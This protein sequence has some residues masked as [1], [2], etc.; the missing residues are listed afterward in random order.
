MVFANPL[1]W[2]KMYS[3]PSG[4][5]RWVHRVGV[6]LVVPDTTRAYH[7]LAATGCNVSLM[8]DRTKLLL[9]NWLICWNTVTCGVDSTYSKPFG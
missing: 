4:S 3:N 6:M 8:P 2:N 9:Q 5:A 1:L 7:S